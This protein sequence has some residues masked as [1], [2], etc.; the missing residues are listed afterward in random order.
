MVATNSVSGAL[1]TITTITTNK[2]N[3]ANINSFKN[4]AQGNTQQSRIPVNLAQQNNKICLNDASGNNVNRVSDK[5]QP[6]VTN[7]S[8]VLK[9]RIGKCGGINCNNTNFKLQNPLNYTASSYLNTQATK[10][11][12]CVI[13]PNKAYSDFK[14]IEK[15][16]TTADGKE[17]LICCSKPIVKTT[18]TP[19]TSTF[20]R[21]EY[22]KKNCLPQPSPP[23]NGSIDVIKLMLNK[24]CK[25][26]NRGC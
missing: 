22:F 10:S 17:I 19:T 1:F 12:Q 20:L 23:N 16:I 13:N 6:T 8:S 21:T 2:K 18:S 26:S 5:P 14:Q 15:I 24:N 4:G 3:P 11:S 7:T 25:A 9:K